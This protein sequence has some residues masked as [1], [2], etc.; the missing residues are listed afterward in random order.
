VV[1]LSARLAASREET[2]GVIR[3]KMWK[4]Y[5]LKLAYLVLGRLSLRTL[6]GIANFFGTAAYYAR[7]KARSDV[8][9]N[10]RQVMGPQASRRSVRAA[11]REAF[12]NAARYYADLLYVP[13][14]DIHHFA[15]EQLD[16][17]GVE[18]LTDAQQ[19]GRG[20][21]VVSAHF[22][23]PELVVQGL[24]ADGFIFFSLTE[25]LQPKALSDF[26]HWLRSRH[27]HVY[28]TLSLGG[29]K[30]AVQ[31]LKSGGLVALL[32][33]R[34]VAGTGV[35]MEFCGAITKIPLGAVDLALRTGADLIPAWGWRID[36]FRFRA[37]IGPPLALERTGDFDAD[38]RANAR[39]L[40]KIFECR[41]RS[42]PGQWA[43]LE[44]IWD[45]ASVTPDSGE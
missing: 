36:G 40:L 21:V 33:D 32:L 19:S 17:K 38:V 37:E 43:V 5:T 45:G 26:T 12:R 10:M 35:P 42:D 30:E 29:V 4:Y 7:H 11:A 34:D 14:M 1:H 28:R 24:A 27:G 44:R 8:I 18:Y 31:R 6:Y 20:A 23:S 15:R 16:I 9:A 2:S 13:G 22:G 25:P 39:K 3:D 41:L